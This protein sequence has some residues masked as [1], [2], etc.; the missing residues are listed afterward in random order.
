MIT[1]TTA[2]RFVELQQRFLVG[3]DRRLAD[4]TM[5]LDGAVD[6]DALMRMFHS[7]AGIGGT[8]GFPQITSISR[9]C[10]TLCN[11]VIEE[12][13][14]V[15]SEERRYLREAIGDIRAAQSSQL[16]RAA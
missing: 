14:N 4:L 11:V 12:R 2:N 16:Q 10:E 13:R 7:L 9:S 8:Y 1:T 3:L 6:S 5:A 15:A